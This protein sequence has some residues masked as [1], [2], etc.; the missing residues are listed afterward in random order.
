MLQKL[1]KNVV[2]LSAKAVVRKLL[3]RLAAEA[4]VRLSKNSCNGCNLRGVI[5]GRDEVVVFVS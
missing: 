3:S 1:D 5:V 4:V 2:T